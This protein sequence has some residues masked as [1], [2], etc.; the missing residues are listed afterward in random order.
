MNPHDRHPCR[1][2]GCTTDV[3]LELL[4]CETHWSLVP[5]EIRRRI[6]RE[7][8]D[9]HDGHAAAKHRLDDAVQQAIASLR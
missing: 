9:V 6:W 1:A 2:T 4:M 8:Q 3:G 5:I 7:W